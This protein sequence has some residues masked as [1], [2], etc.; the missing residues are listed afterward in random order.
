MKKENELLENMKSHKGL[1]EQE[2]ENLKQITTKQELSEKYYEIRNKEESGVIWLEN[3]AFVTIG[4][5]L[6]KFCQYQSLE[7][8]LGGVTIGIV[9]GTLYDKVCKTVKMQKFKKEN[10]KLLTEPLPNK[11]SKDEAKN[12]AQ[13]KQETIKIL[14]SHINSYEII[15]EQYIQKEKE[16]IE[17]LPA[18]EILEEDNLTFILDN[19]EYFAN[20]T[21]HKEEITERQIDYILDHLDTLVDYTDTKD[22]LSRPK[23]VKSTK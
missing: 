10:E 8:L 1:I 14:N 12:L 2:I 16:R 23:L 18:E 21:S 13:Q 9:V 3:C 15:K 22:N 11:E 7:S 4:V 6:A 20:H 19:L 5:T 17:K